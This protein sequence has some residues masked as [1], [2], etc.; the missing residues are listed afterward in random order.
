MKPI[1]HL[2][3]FFSFVILN[4][5]KCQVVQHS[6]QINRLR[7]YLKLCLNNKK[8]ETKYYGITLGLKNVHMK[9]LDK[10]Q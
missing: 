7:N 5:P 2:N 6:E 3:N 9:K 1:E 8:F 10:Y 4:P